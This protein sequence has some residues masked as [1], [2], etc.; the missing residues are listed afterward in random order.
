MNA[1][2][3]EAWMQE[4]CA[5]CPERGPISGDI[6][7]PRRMYFPLPRYTERA[8]KAR[9]QGVVI[10]EAIIDCDG[11]V[12]NVR[13]LKGLPLGLAEQAVEALSQWRFEP[14][15]VNGGIPARVIYNLTVNFRL[16]AAASAGEPLEARVTVEG[17]LGRPIE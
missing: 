13:V 12:H 2:R 15:R 1:F 8:R 4:P 6:E 11:R 16:Q 3:G 14:A 5:S 9:I 17:R 10:C 7:A